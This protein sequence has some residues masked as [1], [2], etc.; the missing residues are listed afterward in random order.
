MLLTH[1]K[2][3]FQGLARDLRQASE[4]FEVVH[5]SYIMLYSFLGVVGLVLLVKSH[6][7]SPKA[8]PNAPMSFGFIQRPC[9]DRTLGWE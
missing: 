9:D 5:S 7:K 1:L 2:R 3:C 6:H 4:V 8:R